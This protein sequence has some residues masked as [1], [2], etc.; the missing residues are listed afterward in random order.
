MTKTVL[1]TG[2]TD[3]IG[4]ELAKVLVANGHHVLLHG[5]SA[6][7]LAAVEAEL[8]AHP[9]GGETEA[10][11]ADLS[12]LAEVEALARDVSARH[13]KIDA[14]INNAGIFKTRS[15][16]TKHG[17][18][19]RFVVNTLAPYLL[20]KRL[21]PLMDDGGRVINL[22]SAAQAPVD[23]DA[24]TGRIDLSD[25]FAAYA[26]SK[27]GLTMWSR[28]MAKG[29]RSNGPVIVAVN[30][31]SLLGTKMV[32]QGFGTDGKD[33]S[34]GANILNRAVVSDDFAEASGL[35]FDNDLGRF[36]Q[37]HPDAMDDRKCAALTVLMDQ[38]LAAAL[39][40]H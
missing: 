12:D 13:G 22:S 29:L 1:L 32:K 16:I 8:A 25:D 19:S 9:N 37:P 6:S 35:Y 28:A 15:P 30:P 7:K 14:L 38:T 17:L 36:A 18:D 26:Q 34:I 10:L 4:L 5:R 31:G 40:G 33:I 2:A 39:N 20:T 27:L 11:V 24:L 23:P 3:G 21:L